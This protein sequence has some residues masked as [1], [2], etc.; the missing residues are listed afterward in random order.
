MLV[1]PIDE[2]LYEI[3]INRITEMKNIDIYTGAYPFFGV[4]SGGFV[5]NRRKKDEVLWYIY[6]SLILYS[7]LT[8]FGV[9]FLQYSGFY[10]AI[11]IGF[12]IQDRFRQTKVRCIFKLLK[13]I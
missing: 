6:I 1:S 3:F 4:I 12:F 11:M 7:V 13:S 5:I 9:R 8:W 2:R 10:S